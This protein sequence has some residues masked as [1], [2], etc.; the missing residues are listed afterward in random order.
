MKHY[1][2]SVRTYRHLSKE[3]R[4]AFAGSALAR[5]GIKIVRN[6]SGFAP[7]SPNP[8]LVSLKPLER[9]IYT[10]EQPEAVV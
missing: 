2:E 3:E 4:K 1:F 6:N 5:L 7:A 9:P 8:G 10:E